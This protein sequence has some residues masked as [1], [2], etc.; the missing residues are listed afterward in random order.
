MPK[1][2]NL[3]S[4]LFELRRKAGH[5]QYSDFETVI[6][7]SYQEFGTVTIAAEVVLAD[8]KGYGPSPYYCYD[9]SFVTSHSRIVCGYWV[10]GT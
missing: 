5:Q 10:C 9:D 1:D 2:D 8:T 4:L 7:V 3:E 6:A